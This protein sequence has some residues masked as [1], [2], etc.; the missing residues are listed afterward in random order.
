MAFVPA[1]FWPPGPASGGAATD[2]VARDAAASAQAT[3]NAAVSTGAELD[4]LLKSDPAAPSAIR[5]GALN[6]PDMMDLISDP[7]VRSRI[8]AGTSTDDLIP[9]LRAFRTANPGVPLYFRY[10][11]QY[12]LDQQ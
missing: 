11:G 1:D 10:P 5:L 2:Q 7:A 8:L 12:Y 4:A 3:A 6:G 9:I